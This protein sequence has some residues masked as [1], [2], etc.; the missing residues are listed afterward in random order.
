MKSFRTYLLIGLLTITIAPATAFAQ[1]TSIDANRMNR[2]IRIMEN[3]LGELFRTQISPSGSNQT[4]VVSGTGTF[5]GDN[6]RGTYLPGFGVIF[7]VGNT[8]IWGSTYR[9]LS[10]SGDSQYTFYYDAVG[11]DKKKEEVDQESITSRIQSFLRDYASTIGQLKD[12]EKVMVIFGAKNNN[13][14]SYARLLTGRVTTATTTV[15]GQNVAADDEDEKEEI[16]VISVS[17]KVSDLKEFRTGR[18]N[19]DKFED[20]LAVATSKDREYLDLKVMGNIFETALRDQKG[21]AYRL[22]GNVNYLM[23]DNFGA[24]FSF[25]VRYGTNSRRFPTTVTSEFMRVTTG[26]DNDKEKEEYQE[27]LK[28]VTQAF[29]NLKTNVSE[30]IVDYG[31]TLSSVNSDQYLLLSITLSGRL[32]EIPERVDV[33]IKKSVLDQLDRGTISRDAALRQIVINEY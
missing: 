2:D 19:A 21:D 6:V 28:T 25:S 30:Y 7:N 9:V 22:S 31:R 16:P 20:R 1:S 17:T 26:Y 24:L 12:D 10:G 27:Y 14:Y 13:A 32:D 23:L 29:E 4:F 18:I 15:Q 11:S 5:H 33:Q 3:I 8:G